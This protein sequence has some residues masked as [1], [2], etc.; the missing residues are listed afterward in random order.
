M[1]IGKYMLPKMS[2]FLEKTN[3]INEEAS[4]LDVT[5]MSVQCIDLY[6]RSV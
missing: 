2:L 4:K 1:L 6:Y 3:T 5:T